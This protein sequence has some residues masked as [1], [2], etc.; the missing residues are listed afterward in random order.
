MD[1]EKYIFTQCQLNWKV[2]FVNMIKKKNFLGIR[3]RPFYD[4]EE[5]C[6]GIFSLKRWKKKFF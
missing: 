1:D 2:L 4:T 6:I 5:F 3:I